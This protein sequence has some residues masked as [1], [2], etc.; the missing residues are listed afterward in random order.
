MQSGCFFCWTGF[1]LI[2]EWSADLALFD[3]GSKLSCVCCHAAD[4]PFR[5]DPG[6]SEGTEPSKPELLLLKGKP[7][8]NL[9]ASVGPDFR[10]KACGQQLMSNALPLL[11][12]QL[13]LKPLVPHLAMILDALLPV[14]TGDATPMAFVDPCRS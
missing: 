8:F 12:L 14:L 11:M 7:P 4:E 6:L 5:E 13:D 3:S 2:P 9:N 1:N 10:A